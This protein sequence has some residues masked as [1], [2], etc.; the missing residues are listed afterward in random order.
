MPNNKK[1]S[2]W[3][4]TLLR[5]VIGFIFLYH[6]YLKLF[7]PGVF[8]GTIGFFTKV[9]IIAPQISALVVSFAEFFGGLFLILGMITRWATFALIF[10]ML[11]AFF[12]IHIKNGILV[13]SNGYEF[14]LLIMTALLLIHINGAG[15]LSLGKLFKK[16]ILE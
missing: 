12:T 13:S 1:I 3:S 4:I 10:E 8:V 7:V 9:G 15:R 5:V 2:Q 11:V 16:K 6:G 14:V